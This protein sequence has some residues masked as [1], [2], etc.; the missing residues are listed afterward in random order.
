M[1]RKRNEAREEALAILEQ[2]EQAEADEEGIDA[3]T[4]AN[5]ERETENEGAGHSGR[6][7]FG[8]LA[9]ASRA[10]NAKRSKSKRT[11]DDYSDLDLDIEDE[12]DDDDDVEDN[13][14]G[15]KRKFSMHQAK[16]AS[17]KAKSKKVYMLCF[18]SI[19][20]ISNLI[21]I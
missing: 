9:V 4:A 8:D 3:D 13:E 12:D 10:Q 15:K 18:R 2:L 21:F 1:E 5:E 14:A 20:F 17:P 6:L 19:D 7:A 11:D 16:K